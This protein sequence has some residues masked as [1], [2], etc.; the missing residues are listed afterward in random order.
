MA[1]EANITADDKFFVG[2]DKKIR[3]P[4]YADAALTTMQ[5]VSG[6]AL[7][8]K[9]VTAPGQAALITKTSGAGIAVTG[10]FNASPS[11]NTQRVEI[12]IDDT[13][14]DGLSA[15]ASYYHELKRT[16]AGL[17]AVL[18]HGRVRLKARVHLT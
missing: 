8:W 9:L 7:S 11:L 5:D 14:T 13:D 18:M 15:A 2:E 4:V 16:D 3:L 6:F 17:E 10:V 1:L 12:T